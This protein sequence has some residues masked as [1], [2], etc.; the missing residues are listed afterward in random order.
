MTVPYINLGDFRS[1][2]SHFDLRLELG[3][4]VPQLGARV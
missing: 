3:A 2:G 1:R 4:G